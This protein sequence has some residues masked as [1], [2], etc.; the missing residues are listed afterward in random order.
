[1]PPPERAALL[2]PGVEILSAEV[3][4]LPPV[5][6]PQESMVVEATGR[7]GDIRDESVQVEVTPEVAADGIHPG[8]QIRIL[9]IDE[10]GEGAPYF[11][12]DHERGVPLGALFVLYL[13]V[14]ALVARGSGLRA[15]LGLAAGVAIVVLFMLPAILAGEN[16]VLVALVGSS[17]MI[18]PC[19]Y[20]AHGIS[21]RTTTAVLGT[22]GGIAITVVATSRRRPPGRDDGHGGRGGPAARGKLSRRCRSR[23]SSWPA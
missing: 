16:A 18:F 6:P 2:A 1:M 4:K 21:I 11:Y 22:F 10:A 12:F 7:S 8:D 17:A 20:F 23:P 3:T 13:L 9:S 19:V 5:A 15:V 14:V